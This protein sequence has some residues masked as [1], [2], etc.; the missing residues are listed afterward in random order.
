MNISKLAR[1]I[2]LTSFMILITFTMIAILNFNIIVTLLPIIIP[3][4]ILTLGLPPYLAIK[5]VG[6]DIS[7]KTQIAEKMN[8][9]KEIKFNQN[10]R[11]IKEKIE[12]IKKENFYDES[13]EIELENTLQKRK[14]IK[15]GTM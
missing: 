14:V 8:R 11:G 5:Q 6:K 13:Q 1:K 10:K 15:K 4:G 9:E 2:W 3:S 7:K 12:S